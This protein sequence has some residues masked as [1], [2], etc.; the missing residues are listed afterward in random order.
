VVTYVSTQSFVKDGTRVFLGDEL[1][2]IDGWLY[3]VSSKKPYRFE[4]DPEKDFPY[5]DWAKRVEP[6]EEAEA[7]G[8]SGSGG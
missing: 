7:P 8:D 3:V 4:I 5:G 6:I 1:K 2:I